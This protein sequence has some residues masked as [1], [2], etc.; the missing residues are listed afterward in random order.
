[1]SNYQ[2]TLDFL[3]EKLPMFQ[4]IGA[5]AYKADLGN[6]IALCEL[7]GN[8]H[9]DLKFVHIA[10]TNGKGSVTHILASVLQAA[11]Y[12]VGVFCSPHYIDYR[13]RIKINGE[14]IEKD[15]VINFVE[16]YK[17]DFLKLDASFFEITNALA[18]HY[19]KDKKV[20]IIVLETG[21]GGRL[22]STNIV[23]PE[24]SV[25][26]N[27]SYDHQQ[28]L[29]N[30]LEKIAAEKAGII[31]H[32]KPIVIG[33]T[34]VETKA[35]FLDK[36]LELSAPIFFADEKISLEL[37]TNN[38][39]GIEFLY[40][41]NLFNTD[42]IG[43]YQIKNIKTSL[44]ALNILNE[45]G[46][47]ISSHDIKSGLSN[48]RKSTYFIGR[49][50][51]IQERPLVVLDS[52]HNEGGWRELLVYLSTIHFEK[53]LIVFGTV[54][55]KD[56]NP[57]FDLLPKEAQYFFCKPNIPRGKDANELQKAASEFNLNGNSY[58]SV[59][60]AFNDAKIKATDNDLVL[61]AGSIFVVCEVL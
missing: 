47:K 33:E 18:F 35:V 10:G 55:D 46:W 48:V 19:F 14:L 32:Y 27:I 52:A 23:T 59:S 42:L 51:K 44:L 25:I 12:K 22:D 36:A 26:T 21:M 60:Q 50:M 15:Y 11:G 53:L 16:Q 61:V 34:Q 58:L 3:F 13:E 1:M 45:I 2:Q 17:D 39:N 43:E 8:P 9:Q 38:L 7:L 30:T 4:R 28:F 40:N 29:G 57:I 31:K 49:M 24:L 56:L 5:A 41:G 37:K 20:D 54:A 6:I